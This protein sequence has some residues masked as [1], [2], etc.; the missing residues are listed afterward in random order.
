MPIHGLGGFSDFLTLRERG[1][2]FASS[3]LEAAK[4]LE[5]S[6]FFNTA[7]GSNPC[8]LRVE[9][10]EALEHTQAGITRRKEAR[11]PFASLSRTLRGCGGIDTFGTQ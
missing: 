5:P 10:L 2:S 9:A 7:F 3:R 6:A 8:Q 11:A 1:G 4:R